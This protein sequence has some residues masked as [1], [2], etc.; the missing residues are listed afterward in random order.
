[1]KNCPVER[2][3]ER[4]EPDRRRA[5]RRDYLQ[6]KSDR[7]FVKAYHADIAHWQH[8]MAALR[9]R[10]ERCDRNGLD[11]SAYLVELCGLRAIIE[12]RIAKF[13]AQS[14]ERRSTILMASRGAMTHLVAAIDQ[15][16]PPNGLVDDSV[17]G[18]ATER[19]PRTAI[20]R[21]GTFH[22]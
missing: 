19:E 3:E 22:S 13:D 7:A 8:R 1:M 14:G 18:L 6:N 12:D 16:A 17:Q 15:I 20:E 21:H 2:L 9:A 5:P 11:K 4:M 10:V